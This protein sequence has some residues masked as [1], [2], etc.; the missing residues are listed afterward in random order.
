MAS[1]AD[2]KNALLEEASVGWIDLFDAIAVVK[3]VEG[4]EGRLLL[5]C[6]AGPL[7][8]DLVREGRLICGTWVEGGFERW[9]VTPH[10]AADAVAEH[11]R[12]ASTGDLD[13][14]PGEPCSFARGEV[15]E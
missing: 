3:I 7:V 2:L 6:R 5:L 13:P 11:V 4:G 14:V 1:D 12:R 15:G 9:R 10:E 8:V